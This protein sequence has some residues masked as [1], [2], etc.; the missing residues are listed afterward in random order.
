MK[1]SVATGQVSGQVEAHKAQVAPPVTS[2]PTSQ[3]TSQQAA[4][5]V[6]QRNADI[7]VRETEREKGAGIFQSPAKPHGGPDNPPSGTGDGQG[8]E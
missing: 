7:P 2:R 6:H 5:V 3:A 1:N 4:R 8:L